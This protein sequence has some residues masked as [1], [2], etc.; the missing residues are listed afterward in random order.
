ML[1]L[2]DLSAAF[3]TVD[4]DILLTRLHS[5][6]SISG[7]AIEWFHSYLTS[8]SQFVLIK[9]CRSQSRELK[10]GVPQGSV[11]GP[12]LYVLYTAPLADILRFHEMQF[13]F[14]ADDT[15][16]YIS[17]STNNDMELTNSITKIEECLSDIDKWMSI[18]RLKLHKDKT[19]L[20]YLFSK[21][22]PQQSLSPLSFGTESIPLHMQETLA[23]SSI[24]LCKCFPM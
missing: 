19:E 10:W 15:Q 23:L 2:L 4:H 22:N 3:D 17:F 12:I 8:H 1:L 16:L 11:L 7:I 6:Y 20:L 5:E 24:P 9:G 18:N 21:Y 13:H 14:Y